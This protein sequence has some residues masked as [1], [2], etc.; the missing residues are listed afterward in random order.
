MSSSSTSN[1][2]VIKGITETEFPGSRRRVIKDSIENRTVI[3]YPSS[4]R[5]IV[6]DGK[7]QI[8]SDGAAKKDKETELLQGYQV[9]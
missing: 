5:R 3:E 1:P 8:I 9:K 4:G 2:S 7:V 6:K